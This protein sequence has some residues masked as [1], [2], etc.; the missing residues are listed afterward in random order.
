MTT[1]RLTKRAEQNLRSIWHHVAMDSPTGADRLSDRILQSIRFL[2]ANP[3]SGTEWPGGPA[4]I[5][6]HPV[7]GT[8][9]LIFFYPTSYG[10]RIA[11]IIH[12][13][14]DLAAI[15]PS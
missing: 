2:A 6:C 3:I 4:K 11:H 8:D 9:Y 12:G 14:R 10:V 5:R 1:Y 15:F 7:P 13:G